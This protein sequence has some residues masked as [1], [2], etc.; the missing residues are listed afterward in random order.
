MNVCFVNEYFPPFERGGAERSLEARARAL[1][2]RG[3]RVTIVTPNWGAEAREEREG[4]QVV[5]FAFLRPKKHEL[6]P[7]WLANPIFYLWTALVIYRVARRER[8]EVI[9]ALLRPLAKIEVS[10]RVLARA[11]L[12]LPVGLGTL[13][14]IHLASALLWRELEGLPHPVATHDIELGRAARSLGV[15]VIGC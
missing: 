3:H 11:S 4:F 7:K 6:R 9:H 8:A 10:A 1:A 5:R 12:P 13:D 15:A 2:G 14:A